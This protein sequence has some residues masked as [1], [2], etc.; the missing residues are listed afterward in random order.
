MPKNDYICLTS[1]RQC[2]ICTFLKWICTEAL[3]V[4]NQIRC[5]SSYRFRK[6]RARHPQRRLNLFLNL[7]PSLKVSYIVLDGLHYCV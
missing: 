1:S 6:K 5:R 4:K 2:E 7:Y 3:S